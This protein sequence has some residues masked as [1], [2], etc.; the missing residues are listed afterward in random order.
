ML[1]RVR[2]KTMVGRARLIYWALAQ[3]CLPQENASPACR[4]CTDIAALQITGLLLSGKGGCTPWDASSGRTMRR[5]YTR[6]M[7]GLSRGQGYQTMRR[8]ARMSWHRPTLSLMMSLP[9][10]WQRAK[11]DD[12][13][14]VRVLTC[15]WR[16]KCTGW[17]VHVELL[18]NLLTKHQLSRGHKFP[19]HT[20]SQKT[21][22]STTVPVFHA[23][24]TTQLRHH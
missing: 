3:L 6:M 2:S 18:M 10:C 1:R 20:K 5:I 14:L 17:T 7:T 22:H 24:I 12:G 13:S 11:L 4:L 8:V 21:N 19:K 23:M 15:F 16:G 9:R